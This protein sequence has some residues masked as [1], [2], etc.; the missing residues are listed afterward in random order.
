MPPRCLPRQPGAGHRA[1]D[2]D[3]EPQQDPAQPVPESTP[4][5][6]PAKVSR[7]DGY[8]VAGPQ[9]TEVLTHA[10]LIGDDERVLLVRLALAAVG[11]RR[12]VHSQAGDADHRLLVAE[13]EADEQGSATVVDVHRPQDVLGQRE[14]VSD[15]LQLSYTA[16]E[17][18]IPISGRVVAG[19]R[20]A[21]FFEPSNGDELTAMSR[22][23][24]SADP[25]NDQLGPTLGR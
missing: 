8:L 2:D 7:V 17:S 14:Y 5:A 1:A 6:S 24:G 3:T 4:S 23:P 13:Q 10:C 20:A 22:T 15:Q 25:T 21:E 16:I 11:R 9:Q 18:R 12:L 19:L